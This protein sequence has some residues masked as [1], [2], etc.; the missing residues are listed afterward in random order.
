MVKGELDLALVVADIEIESSCFCRMDVKKDKTG[1][2]DSTT[3]KEEGL[4]CQK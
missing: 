3:E 1:V 4:C 2:E